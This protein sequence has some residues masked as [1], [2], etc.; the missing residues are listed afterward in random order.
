MYNGAGTI[1]KLTE[2]GRCDD[3]DVHRIRETA[4]MPIDGHGCL[5]L[6]HVGRDNDQNVQ[7]AVRMEFTPH[8][9]AEQDDFHRLRDGF[10]NA[11]DQLL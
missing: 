3:D 4:Q 1:G 9:G 8:G 11:L 7:V 10:P 5:L 2:M 6:R